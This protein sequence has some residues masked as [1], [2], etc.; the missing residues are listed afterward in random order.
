[1]WEGCRNYTVRNFFKDDVKV[2]DMAF[3]YHSSTKEIGIVGEMEVVRAGY[4]D[5]TQFDPK[6]EYYAPKS[7]KEKPHWMALDVK[8]VRKYPRVVS[9]QELK[10][11]PGLEKMLVTR[12]GQRLSA[13]PV[14]KEE[15]EIVQKLI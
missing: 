12:K 15:W 14:T 13:M 10:E 2:G 8:F 6:S 7:T 5:P 3:F 11:T 4:P 9:L 1:M